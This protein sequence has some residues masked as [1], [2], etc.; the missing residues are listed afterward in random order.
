[1]VLIELKLRRV[2]RLVVEGLLL[3]GLMGAASCLLSRGEI[4]ANV[5]LKGAISFGLLLPLLIGV[6]IYISDRVFPR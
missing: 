3:G 6:V 4:E 2:L 1:M 5:V